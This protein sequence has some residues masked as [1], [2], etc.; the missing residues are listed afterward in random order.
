MTKLQFLVILIYV[1]F[2]SEM[3][4]GISGAQGWPL[5]DTKIIKSGIFCWEDTF[6]GYKG[7]DVFSYTTDSG[8]ITEK[9]IYSL[10]VNPD[11]V[12]MFPF[13][14]ALI[15]TAWNNQKRKLEYAVFDKSYGVVE[16]DMIALDDATDDLDIRF[17]QGR[18]PA[19]LFVKNSGN[20]KRVSI[21]FDERQ[22]TIF[23]ESAPFIASFLD[24]STLSA[25]VLARSAMK[26]YIRLWQ[27]G[28]VE[29]YEIPF[30]PLVAR[31]ILINNQITMLAIDIRGNLWQVYIAQNKAIASK[32]S[33]LPA[34][35]YVKQL[36]LY[37]KENSMTL[38]MPTPDRKKIYIYKSS[39][40]RRPDGGIIEERP[41][42]DANDVVPGQIANQNVWLESSAAKQVYLNR[43]NENMPTLNNFD[44]IVNMKNGYPEVLFTWKSF[45]QKKNFQ[46]RYIIDGKENSPPLPEYRLNENRLTARL[47]SDGNFYLH[48]QSMDV[49]AGQE[50]VI[51]HI[52]VFLKF[53][54]KTPEI[55]MLDEISPN[56]VSGNGV[57]FSVNNIAP[58]EY[59][60]EITNTP[61]YEPREKVYPMAGEIQINMNLKPGRYY[62]HIRSKDI[63]TGGY[64]PT[65]HY[66]FFCQFYTTEFS[67]GAS[68][69]NKDIGRLKILIKQYND[70]K[71]LDE[72]DKILKELEYLKN[73]LE[74][75]ISNSK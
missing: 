67:L 57:H 11:H 6:Y 16:K 18:R 5:Y 43:E 20:Q 36:D 30:L 64:S 34:L 32:L 74:Q 48:I 68:D 62:I 23:L 38:F 42:I 31:F 47:P 66:L 45:P 59:Y 50:S 73:S 44:W 33:S 21:W 14:D 35:V 39:D 46:Y 70:A 69:F 40:I 71:S 58:L 4:K 8:K 10:T 15:I 49:V 19:F 75:E 63:K 28:L 12:K 1:F 27:K 26:S 9:K 24:W 7:G 13:G 54:L 52:P 3:V 22:Q 61:E 17:G 51:Y 55:S 25:Y 37:I 72:K 53:S 29:S 56:V 41:M 2:S 60:A 65:L